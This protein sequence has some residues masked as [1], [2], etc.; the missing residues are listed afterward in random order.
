[1]AQ[2]QVQK[3]KST[4][5]EETHNDVTNTDVSNKELAEKTDETLENIDD[6][7]DAQFDEELLADMDGLLEENAEE[8]VNNYVQAGGQ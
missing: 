5:T 4:R 7:L 6:V 1:M 8:F 2:E 3:Q